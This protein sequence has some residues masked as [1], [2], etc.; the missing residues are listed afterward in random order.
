MN[1]R[2]IARVPAYHFP[3]YNK[4]SLK[5]MA[6]QKNFTFGSLSYVLVGLSCFVGRMGIEFN[7]FTT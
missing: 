7:L 4:I 1:K 5:S 2:V 3:C 6:F